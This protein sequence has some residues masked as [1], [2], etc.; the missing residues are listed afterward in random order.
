MV[1][2]CHRKLE[3]GG[4][5]KGREGVGGEVP[6]PV[7][8]HLLGQHFLTDG[9]D[10]VLQLQDARHVVALLPAEHIPLLCELS[11]GPRKALG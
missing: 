4:R 6:S 9:L 8:L 10:V 1:S 11:M 7:Q 3:H 2:A 5:K